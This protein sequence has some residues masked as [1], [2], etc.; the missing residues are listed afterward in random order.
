MDGSKIKKNNNC[1]NEEKSEFIKCAEV[2]MVLF[3]FLTISK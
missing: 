3:S 1:E 2:L